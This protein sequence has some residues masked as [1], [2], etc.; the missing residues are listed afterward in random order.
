MSTLF[1]F[2]M[3]WWRKKKIIYWYLVIYSTF[4]SV[5]KSLSSF[6]TLGFPILGF[7]LE[8]LGCLV[9]S[10]RSWGSA[11]RHLGSQVPLFRYAQSIAVKKDWFVGSWNYNRNRNNVRKSLVICATQLAG[12][13]LL[14]RLKYFELMF[15]IFEF[16]Q[17]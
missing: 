16:S 17:V 9:L 2:N 1:V 11:C 13:L 12:G 15:K 7:H 10:P 8:I 4:F 6:P 3:K 14:K 5:L